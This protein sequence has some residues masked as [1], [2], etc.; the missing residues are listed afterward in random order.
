MFN[1]VSLEVEDL[2]LL[3]S[4]QISY[5][6]GWVPEREFGV[7]LQAY[8]SVRRYL[9]KRYP[10]IADFVDQVVTQVDPVVEQQELDDC[11]DQLVWT[12]ADLLVYNKCP[13]AYDS[14]E[15][16]DWDFNE[17]MA[18]TPLDHKVVIEGGAGTGRVTLEAAQAAHQV[19]AVEPVSRLRQFIR[20]KASRADLRNVYVIDG[21][22]DAI[23]L[24]DHFADVLI[25]S[26]AL[27][28]RLESELG[29]FERVVKKGGFIIH[30]PGTTRSEEEQHTRL[31]SADWRYEFSWYQ[32]PDAPKRKYWKRL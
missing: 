2:Y 8:P 3:E 23:P 28:W 24:P 20:E 21:F 18:I 9:V 15:F 4:F 29:Q 32:A 26:H 17:I 30:C 31:V 16:H 27:G 1:G 7:V 14:Q 5:L 12:I 25:T 11:I 19:F 10:P 6:P 13:E 22:L